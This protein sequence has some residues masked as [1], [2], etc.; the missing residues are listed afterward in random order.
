VHLWWLPTLEFSLW[1][2]AALLL[3]FVPVTLIH[4][5]NWRKTTAEYS[6]LRIEAGATDGEWP[7]PET[8]AV[9]GVQPWLLFA[10][11]FLLAA[12]TA[13]GLASLLVWPHRLPG[14]DAA[15]N[16]YDRPYLWSMV[17][18]GTAGVVGVVALGIDLAGSKWAKVARKVRRAIYARPA[19]R[20]RF[21][22]E[23]LAIDPGVPHAGERADET[24]SEAGDT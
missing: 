7:S 24:S 1:P 21:F 3:V 19:E 12:A 11:A 20:T 22:E 5:R 2:C 10:V 4:E 13:V 15:L 17:V 6:R 23:A 14:F 9:M 18:A 16:Y 8:R